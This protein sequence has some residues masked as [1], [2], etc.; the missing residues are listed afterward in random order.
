MRV[1]TSIKK[2]GTVQ[3]MTTVGWSA[4]GGLVTKVLAE[5]SSLTETLCYSNVAIAVCGAV[6]ALR[7]MSELRQI[8]EA[9]EASDKNADNL[10]E[11]CRTLAEQVRFADSRARLLGLS[12][13]LSGNVSHQR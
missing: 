10:V 13:R 3:S 4:L 2:P 11:N 9:C 7:I 6:A 1:I 5:S 12:E 8:E